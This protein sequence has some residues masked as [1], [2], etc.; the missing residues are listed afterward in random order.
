M[1]GGTAP[2][3]AS[4]RGLDRRTLIKGAA[5]AGAA[6]WTAPVL[7]DSLTSPAAAAAC[8]TTPNVTFVT[9]ATSN[10]D[11][12]FLILQ[13]SGNVSPVSGTTFVVLIATSNGGVGGSRVSSSVA[14]I[15]GPPVSG[16]PTLI[17]SV[18]NFNNN[19][20]QSTFDFW[21]YRI[22][23]SSNLGPLQVLFTS[24]ASVPAPRNGTMAIYRVGGATSFTGTSANAGG[25]GSATASITYGNAGSGQ[26]EIWGVTGGDGSATSFGWGVPAGFNWT[27]DSDQ[28]NTANANG[29]RAFSFQSARRTTL[30]ANSGGFTT[31]DGSTPDWAAIRVLCGC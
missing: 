31:S 13:T 5:A 27:E 8:S 21:A 11:S 7:L 22:A 17:S 16:S 25:T 30:T 28:F 9:S 29:F 14:N 2:R 4:E 6:A 19:G 10:G 23:P 18:L 26:A 3:G 1:A 20:T 12:E 15:S 24:S